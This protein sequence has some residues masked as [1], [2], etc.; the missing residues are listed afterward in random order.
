MVRWWSLGALVAAVAALAV[1]CGGDGGGSDEEYVAGICAATKAF[2]QD[3]E[4]L[5]LAEGVSPAESMHKLAPIMADYGKALDKLKAP[6]D[7]KDFQ[8]TYV[9]EVKKAAGLMKDWKEGDGDVF[10]ALENLEPPSAPAKR[11]D[12]VA[13][14]DAVCQEIGFSFSEGTGQ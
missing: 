5:G 7:L 14:K 10:L 12:A 6:S 2:E 11:L 4:A 1:A 8:A 9:R 3:F 13:A